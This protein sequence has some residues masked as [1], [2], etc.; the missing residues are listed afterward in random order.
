MP[1]VDYSGTNGL[2]IHENDFRPKG[3]VAFTKAEGT[4]PG[5]FPNFFC[6]LFIQ[7]FMTFRADTFQSLFCAAD[8]CD[9][10]QKAVGIF[11]RHCVKLLD[12]FTA[13]KSLDGTQI[14]VQPINQLMQFSIGQSAFYFVYSISPE[15]KWNCLTAIELLQASFQIFGITYFDVVRERGV[16]QDIDNPSLLH[17]H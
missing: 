13:I 15:S 9:A 5:F 10:F 11:R 14:R 2:V 16:C 12:P 8:F 3:N 1:V 17:H 4:T 6:D 7:Y